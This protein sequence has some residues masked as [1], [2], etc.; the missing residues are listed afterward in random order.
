MQTLVFSTVNVLS[1]KE[2]MAFIF[3]YMMYFLKWAVGSTCKLLSFVFNEL[4]SSL[5][6]NI[7]LF[8]FTLEAGDI[9]M[10]PG[11]NNINTSL[12]VLHSNIR[13]VHNTFDYLTENFLDFDILRFSGSQY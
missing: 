6:F 4:V 1:N 5:Y 7:V 13:S 8:C 12:S 2:S 10:N 9:E 11:S 3:N